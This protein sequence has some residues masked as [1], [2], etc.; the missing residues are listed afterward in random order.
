MIAPKNHVIN[1]VKN[2]GFKITKQR[3]IIYEA[4]FSKKTHRTAEEILHDARKLHKNVSLATVYRTLKLLQNQGLVIAHNF[5]D[6]HKF[7]EPLDHLLHHDH[8]ICQQCGL[9]TEF[10]NE[11]LEVLQESIAKNHKFTIHHHRM[12]LYGLCHKCRS[13]EQ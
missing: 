11:E 12:E 8:L 6:G 3:S 7:F 9:I 13:L 5:S 10:F 1:H 2:L 4:F